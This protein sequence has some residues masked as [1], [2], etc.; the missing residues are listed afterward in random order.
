MTTRARDSVRGVL[1]AAIAISCIV[2]PVVVV[3][4]DAILGWPSGGFYVVFAPAPLAFATVGWL[5][6]VRRP[7][8]VI[9]PMCL[10]FGLI[11]ATYFP[12]DL[13]VR[14]G[15]SSRLLDLVATFSSSSDAPG[16]ILVAMILILFP[17]GRLPGP[18]WRWTVWAAVVGTVAAVI[19]FALDPG[20]LAAFPSVVNPIGIDGFPGTI[21][22]EIGYVA[23]LVLLVAAVGALVTRWRRGVPVERA[24]IKWV[25][26][27]SV[28][29]LVAEAANLAT[30]NPADPLGSP[31]AVVIASAGT[32]LVP[33]AIGIAILRYR[34]YE[35][36]RLV[37]RTI[38]WAI[39]TALLVAVFAG[40]VVGL[41][42]VLPVASGDTL[43]VAASTLVAFALF[44]PLRR[45]VQRAVDRRFDR[46]RYDGERTAA[47]FGERLRSEVDLGGLESDLADTVRTT[48]HP[49]S[50]HLWIR[51]RA[52][53]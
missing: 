20:P 3:L 49:G 22:G 35:I 4:L 13:L 36:D 29:L 6:T 31:I 26:A 15:A 34:L 38:G 17:D 41:Q 37:S 9:G 10:A 51:G 52:D 32:A 5:L 1:L 23:L 30:F 33:L 14:L 18:R 19:G 40:M 12:L 44:Q 16:F 27:A 47:A 8:N 25:A 2:M 39:V 53:G 21:V 46:A 50:T 43:V 45:R 48:L 24:Q 7:D 11:F 28:V 42:A